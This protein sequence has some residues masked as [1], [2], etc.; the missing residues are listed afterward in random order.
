MNDHPRATATITGFLIVIALVICGC[1]AKAPA[2]NST[3]NTGSNSGESMAK[4]GP[5]TSAG[6][7][8]A[9]VRNAFTQLK[10][11]SFRLHEETN[12]AGASA[13]QVVTRVMEVAP[14]DR[15]HVVL[16]DLEWITI[17]AQRYTKTK[18][19]RT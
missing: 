13:D 11:S 6:D 14:P 15:N 4:S 9:V 8:V 7:D 3:A 16:N 12:M 10:N 18:D 2:T 5:N 1:L 17:G 19:G